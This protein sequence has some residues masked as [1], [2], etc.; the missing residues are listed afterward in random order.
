MALRRRR[1]ERASR[2]K[3]ESLQRM[4]RDVLAPRDNQTKLLF[5][6]L[7]TSV[8]EKAARLHRRHV[9]P[10]RDVV[11][12]DTR[13]RCQA[14]PLIL[15]ACVLSALSYRPATHILSPRPARLSRAR[16]VTA[17]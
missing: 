13:R 8:S 1:R 14:R 16:L 12:P 9:H 17:I 6:D 5:A 11:S 3:T 10:M 7:P 2:D 4:R 15:F